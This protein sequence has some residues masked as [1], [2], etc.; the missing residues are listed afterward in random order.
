[1]DS[2]HSLGWAKQ[3][4]PEILVYSGKNGSVF[5]VSRSYLASHQNDATVRRRYDPLRRQDHLGTQLL[6]A[7][8]ETI[9]P[10]R[11]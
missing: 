3:K 11:T 7:S 5:K 10:D 4:Q 6:V 2:R 1:M 9:E 8:V